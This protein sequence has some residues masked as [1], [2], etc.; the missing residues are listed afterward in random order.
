MVGKAA[1][2]SLS[3]PDLFAVIRTAGCCGVMRAFAYPLGCFTMSD[4][5][6]RSI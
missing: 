1:M 4:V 5:L 2:S 6:E 3:G